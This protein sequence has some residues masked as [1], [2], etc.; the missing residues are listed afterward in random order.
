MNIEKIN[1]PVSVVAEFA[2]GQCTPRRFVWQKR[3]LEVDAVN[4]RWIDRGGD[5]PSLNYSVQAGEETYY[6]RF[7]TG[8]MQWWLEQV[9][10]P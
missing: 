3:T 10:V 8:A 1:Q 5:A 4:A 7:L 2:G 6:L 9:A